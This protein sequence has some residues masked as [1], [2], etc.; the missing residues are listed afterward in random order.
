MAASLLTLLG[1]LPA[2]ATDLIGLEIPPYPDGLA[3]S[4]G[5]CVTDMHGYEHVC[6]YGI[7]LVDDADGRP[8]YIFAK[9]SLGHDAR[10]RRWRVLDVIPHPDVAADEYHAL[11]T[12]RLRGAPDEEP[13]PAIVAVVGLGGDVEWFDDV[14]RAWRLD[15]AQKRLVELPLAGIECAN[16]GYGL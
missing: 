14:R 15:F 1:T 13:D 6:D 9:Q 8:R 2:A 4:Q 11:G 7:A 16:E 10:G 3:S 5:S 12:W